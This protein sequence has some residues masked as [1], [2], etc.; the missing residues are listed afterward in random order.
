MH[1]RWNINFS[2]FPAANRLDSRLWPPK[3]RVVALP[4]NGS[5]FPAIF[6][7]PLSR[8]GF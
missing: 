4:S 6:S 3:N 7:S 1:R 2:P 5:A 8:S